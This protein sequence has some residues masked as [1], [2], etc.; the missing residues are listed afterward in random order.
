MFRGGNQNNGDPNILGDGTIQGYKN[1]TNTIVVGYSEKQ[2]FGQKPTNQTIQNFQSAVNAVNDVIQGIFLLSYTGSTE[3]GMKGIHYI[4]E[5]VI[6]PIYVAIIQDDVIQSSGFQMRNDATP[7][8][9][10]EGVVRSLGIRRNGGGGD[11]PYISDNPT[12]PTFINDGD[13]ALQ[14]IYLFP[15]GFKLK[16]N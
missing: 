6:Q 3:M 15:P 7:K 1:K 13:R 9:V 16:T 11:Y 5:P 14:L 10:L 2:G 4:V 8:M 12:S